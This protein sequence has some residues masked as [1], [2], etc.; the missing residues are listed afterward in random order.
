MTKNKENVDIYKMYANDALATKE[1]FMSTNS[2][3]K[4]GISE[5]E[6]ISRLQEYGLNEIKQTRTKK[7][8]STTLYH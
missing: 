8:S 5:K 6:A 3:R 4:D 2:V 1:K 7:A